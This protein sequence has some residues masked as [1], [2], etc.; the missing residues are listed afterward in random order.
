MRYVARLSER[1]SADHAGNLSMRRLEH[2]LLQRPYTPSQVKGNAL[3]D[4]AQSRR[5]ECDD[6]Q[7]FT[8]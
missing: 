8:T 3:R 5:S 6:E 2:T 1:Q 7:L 4:Q